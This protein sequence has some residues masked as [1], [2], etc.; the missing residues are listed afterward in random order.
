[1]SNFLSINTNIT[2]ILLQNSLTRSIAG[3]NQAAERISSGYRI[4]SAADDPAGLVMAENF[5]TR[6]NEAEV[7]IRS[8]EFGKAYLDT[9]EYAYSQIGD[10][11]ADIKDLAVEAQN[12][13]LTTAERTTLADELTGH[14]DTLQ[15]YFEDE[16]DG[17]KIFDDNNS[18]TIY[19]GT[20]MSSFNINVLFDD[21][22]DDTANAWDTLFNSASVADVASAGALEDLI[23]ST[24]EGG[25]GLLDDM[26]REEARAGVDSS[27]LSDRISMLEVKKT[28]YMAVESSIR[29]ADVAAET[30]NTTK[31]QLLQQATTTLLAQA[32][33][34]PTLALNLISATTGFSYY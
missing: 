11:L 24:S 14:L 27:I 9:V 33:Q 2:S 34:G 17:R 3:Y 28:N 10:T 12:S 26:V 21:H 7:A 31:Y 23:K 6:V 22:T 20:E 16:Y 8:A 5:K 18:K 29:D 19:L 1:M 13:L 30:I 15:G 25:S 32:N 4:N